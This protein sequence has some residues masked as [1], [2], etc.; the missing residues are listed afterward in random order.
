MR[1]VV[2]QFGEL[3]VSAQTQSYT[4]DELGAAMQEAGFAEVVMQPFLPELTLLLSGRKP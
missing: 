2:F 4:I 3:T 1:S